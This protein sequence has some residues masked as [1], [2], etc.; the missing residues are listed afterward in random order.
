MAPI[1]G[2]VPDPAKEED[3]LRRAAMER[4]LNYMGLSPNEKLSEVK[5]DK[6][7]D[8]AVAVDGFCVC[9]RSLSSPSAPNPL[10]DSLSLSFVCVC[11]CARVCVEEYTHTHTHTHR[12]IIH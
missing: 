2:N 10:C 3:P 9:A 6:V 8:C 5:I 7:C 4:S 1:T 11:V 12:C